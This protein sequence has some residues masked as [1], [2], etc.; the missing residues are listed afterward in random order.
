VQLPCEHVV[1]LALSPTVDI[2]RLTSST[3]FCAVLCGWQAHHDGAAGFCRPSL[4]DCMPLLCLL[5]PMIG[6]HPNHKGH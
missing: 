3:A 2:L 4:D 6:S 1:Q 5:E